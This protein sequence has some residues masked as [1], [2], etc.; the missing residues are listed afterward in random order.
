VAVGGNHFHRR[1]RRR[2]LCLKLSLLRSFG[3]VR[4]SVAAILHCGVGVGQGATTTRTVKTRTMTT[5]RPRTVKSW[6]RQQTSSVSRLLLARDRK[7][8]AIRL[9]LFNNMP[10]IKTIRSHGVKFSAQT[11]LQ[12]AVRVDYPFWRDH[13]LSDHYFNCWGALNKVVHCWWWSWWW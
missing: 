6:R 1:C 12:S 13:A 7:K 8:L 2:R 5:M 10:T 9:T 3:G 11:L 4:W